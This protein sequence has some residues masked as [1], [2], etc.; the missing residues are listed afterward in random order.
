MET[1]HIATVVCLLLLFGSTHTLDANEYGRPECSIACVESREE[2]LD[3]LNSISDC[4]ACL[5]TNMST[6]SVE[7]NISAIVK[8][9]SGKDDDTNCT[10]KSNETCK[11][12]VLIYCACDTEYTNQPYSNSCCNPDCYIQ[13][14]NTC[15]CNDCVWDV[16]NKRWIHNR[17]KT[18]WE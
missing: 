11:G 15:E 9:I 5:L 10:M 1:R 18:C 4:I 16:T 8:E 2:L 17:C 12:D 3:Y 6:D 13:H 7:E 14:P